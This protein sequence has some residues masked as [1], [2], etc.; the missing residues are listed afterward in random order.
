MKITL[1]ECPIGVENTK[2]SMFRTIPTCF[3]ASRYLSVETLEFGVPFR[4]PF[5][6]LETESFRLF[7]WQQNE[8]LFL[9]KT[10]LTE[11]FIYL[12]IK[13]CKML[14]VLGNHLDQTLVSETLP[15]PSL[16]G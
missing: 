2:V 7:Q 6:L 4:F 9:C 11:S 3:G 10:S 13:I 16:E 12:C 15:R 1:L 14:P 5:V 8:I